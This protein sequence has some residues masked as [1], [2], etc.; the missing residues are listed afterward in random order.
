MDSSKARR[1]ESLEQTPR[2]FS[3][4]LE[5]N[6][7]ELKRIYKLQNRG[8]P[9]NLVEKLVSEI[10]FTRRGSVLKANNKTQKDILP[11]VTQYQPSVPN[12][13]KALLTKCHLI[14]NQPQLR[15]IV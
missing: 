7:S 5:E 14:R 10:K 12:L 1:Y 2:H 9:C 6:I 4:H 11:C 15:Q 13:K 3:R 8:Y